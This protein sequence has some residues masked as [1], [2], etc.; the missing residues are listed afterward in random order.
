MLICSNTWVAG[1][2]TERVLL[3]SNWQ[4]G[5]GMSSSFSSFQFLS[6]LSLCFLSSPGS[7]SFQNLPSHQ[8]SLALPYFVPSP[9]IPRPLGPP[10]LMTSLAD[11]QECSE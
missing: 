7:C 5:I 9:S 11:N 8:S 1:F 6:R 10:D 3:E 4:W 2:I